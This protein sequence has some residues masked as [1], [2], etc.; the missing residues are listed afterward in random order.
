MLNSAAHG[1]CPGVSGWEVVVVGLSVVGSS[2]AVVG[3]DLV[4][5]TVVLVAG[6]DM[7][8]TELASTQELATHSRPVA[9]IQVI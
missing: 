6:V 3:L 9:Q 4:V 2:V 1:S 7:R 5:C 8:L